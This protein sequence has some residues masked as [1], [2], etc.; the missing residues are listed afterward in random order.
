MKASA[1]AILTESPL[2]QTGSGDDEDRKS[3]HPKV[4]PA[5]RKSRVHSH[6][7]TN[8]DHGCGTVSDTGWENERSRLESQRVP[9]KGNL[10][11]GAFEG[12]SGGFFAD[13]L[14]SSR[15]NIHMPFLP[16]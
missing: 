1:P 2:Q 8:N 16:S 13:I 3:A 6:V 14:F 5:T 9:K 11:V 7:D 12:E 15:H 4:Q 10:L